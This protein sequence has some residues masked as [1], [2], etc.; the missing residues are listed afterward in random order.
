MI[1]V[2]DEIFNDPNQCNPQPM[3]S[4][5]YST[6]GFTQLYDTSQWD[7]TSEESN[8]AGLLTYYGEIFGLTN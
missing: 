1:N 5:L 8:V 2:P 7:L 3:G 4:D 6:G